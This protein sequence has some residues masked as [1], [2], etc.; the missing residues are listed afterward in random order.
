[1]L[2]K[3]FYSTLILLWITFITGC[4][5]DDS[6]TD[7]NNMV[8]SKEFV[9]TTL[10]NTQITVKEDTEGFYIDGQKDK[11]VIFDIFATWCPPCQASASHLSSIQD[12]YKDK[13]IIVGVTIE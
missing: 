9:L 7:A 6:A 4:S 13:V 5:N 12:K 2:K 10:N 3:A 8:S 11:L 1:M